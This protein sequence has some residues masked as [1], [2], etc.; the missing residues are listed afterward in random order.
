VLLFRNDD[1]SLMGTPYLD[2]AKVTATI[3]SQ[4][5]DD[6]ILV[7]KYKAKSGY[8]RTRGHRQH[9]T[10]VRIDTIDVKKVKE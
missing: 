7:Y 5:R 10:A 4:G 1:T 3:T 6:K 9:K 2:S 8:R